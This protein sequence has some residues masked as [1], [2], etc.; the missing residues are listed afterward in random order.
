MN[1]YA[2]YKCNFSCP[3][4][5]IKDNNSQKLNLSWVKKELLRHPEL[6]SDINILGGEPS[7]LPEDYQEE[8]INIC[9][10]VAN[11]KPYY[12]TNLFKISPL[13]KK[14]KLIVSYD[15]GLRQ[16]NHEVLNNILN[17]EQ[18]FGLSTVL[19]S[20][21]VDNIGANKY[22]RFINSLSNCTRADLDLYYKSKHDINNF[23]PKLSNLL[24]FIFEVMTNDKVNLAP[25]SSMRNYIDGSI[26]NISDFFAFMPGEK[27]GVR[28]DYDNGPYKIFDNY[29]DAISFYNYRIKHNMC[30]NC[31]FINSCWYPCSSNT[32][33]GCRP[34]L[35]MFK[36]Y[37]LSSSR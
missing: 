22:L 27:Y 31:E 19:T 36:Q 26:Y 32:C 23:T 18:E 13:L 21:L 5:S 6:C 7:I 11:E 12:I 17:L 20:Y 8:L 15:F 37:V 10:E 28:L 34:M 24:N 4:C 29:D 14:C 35:E 2:S 1:I 25:L 30:R 33:H 9:T 3:F 16:N